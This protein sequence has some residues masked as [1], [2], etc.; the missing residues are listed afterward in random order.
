MNES[1]EHKPLWR[2]SSKNVKEFVRAGDQFEAWD[3]LQS[4]PASDFGIIVTSEPDEMGDAGI[5]S[6]HTAALMFSWGRTDDAELAINAAIA[7][8]LGDTSD[9]DIALGESVARTRGHHT[10]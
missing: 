7:L 2:I 1:I 8:G 4:R 5:V 10:L 3:T 9:A 6:I